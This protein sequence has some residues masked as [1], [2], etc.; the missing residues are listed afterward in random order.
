MIT[1]HVAILARSRYS[2]STQLKSC[3]SSYGHN[4]SYR[5]HA[6][7]RKNRLF[8]GSQR[9]RVRNASLMSLV[10]SALRMDLDVGRHLV[11]VLTHMLRETPKT[12]EL[13]P[14]RWTAAHLPAGARVPRARATRYGRYGRCASC[15]A[16]ATSRAPQRQIVRQKI[17]VRSGVYPCVSW[18]LR[19]EPPNWRRRVSVGHRLPPHCW[20]RGGY[21]PHHPSRACNR[22]WA[23]QRA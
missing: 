10:A 22:P 4:A 8:I 14:D 6:V 23:Y 20:L 3:D 5:S 19:T 16:S 13:L 17:H 7:G 12:E 11:S 2:R 1:M 9:A 15:T 21:E 18:A